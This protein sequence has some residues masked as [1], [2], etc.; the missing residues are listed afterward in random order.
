M[1][2]VLEHIMSKLTGEQRDAYAAL[3]TLFDSYGLSSLAPRILEFVQQ[4]YGADTISILLQETNEYKQRFAANEQRKKAGLPVLSP[5]EYLATENAYRQIMRSSGMPSGFWDQ[6]SDFN[7]LIAGD[8]SPT[9]LKTRVDIAVLATENA[10][11]ATKEALRQMGIPQSNITAYFLDP[12]RSE[13]L[14]KK[15]VGTAQIGG[16]AMRNQLE[17]NKQRAE[18]WYMQ[19]VTAEQAQQGFGAISGFLGDVSKLGRLYGTIYDQEMAEAEVF[20]SSGEA[21]NVRKGLASRERAQF[22]GAT[23]GARGGLSIKRQT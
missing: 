6:P 19:G 14:I 11:P 5:Q 17:F 18:Q 2:T 15:Q 20:G 22:S 16:A 1:T 3:R 7:T 21:A 13:T 9:E 23:G 8:V 12:K 10:D 4:G